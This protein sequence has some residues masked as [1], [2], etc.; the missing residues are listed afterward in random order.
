MT[1]LLVFTALPIF[2]RDETSSNHI[3][4]CLRIPVAGF[5]PAEFYHVASGEL[6]DS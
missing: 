1:Y 4:H 5:S 2:V 3:D 6:P